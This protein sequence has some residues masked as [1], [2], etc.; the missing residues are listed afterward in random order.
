VRFVD[1]FELEFE[2]LP[3]ARGFLPRIYQLEESVVDP[4]SI[5]YFL[6]DSD[7]FRFRPAQLVAAGPASRNKPFWVRRP[8]GWNSG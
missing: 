1:N 4:Y 6:V 2:H 7:S 8:L 5:S 3:W